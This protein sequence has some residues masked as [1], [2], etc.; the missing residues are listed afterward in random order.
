MGHYLTIPFLV[1]F[2][3]GFAYVGTLSLHQR[4]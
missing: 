3:V 2:A 1:V 4:S